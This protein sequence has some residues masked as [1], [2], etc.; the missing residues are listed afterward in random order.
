MEKVIKRLLIVL[1]IAFSASFLFG[2]EAHAE[3]CKPGQYA[4]YSKADGSAG[5][6]FNCVDTSAGNTKEKV[7]YING[8]LNYFAMTIAGLSL[9]FG[10]TMIVYAGFLYTTS[11]GD[12]K[13]VQRAKVTIM[14]A[15]I[16][17]FIALCSFII[18]A[19]V[20]SVIK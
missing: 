13:L 19:I 14:Q 3:L 9:G 16:G 15:G 4:A 8:Y 18:Y 11:G 1:L 2:Q 17:M 6:T 20:D 12:A 7:G 5:G 10:V